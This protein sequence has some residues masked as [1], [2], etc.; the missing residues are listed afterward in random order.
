MHGFLA[1][2]LP[3][4]PQLERIPDEPQS[5]WL[6]S[7]QSACWV[8]FLAGSKALLWSCFLIVCLPW[9]PAPQ[10]HLCSGCQVP[11]FQNK[12]G[13]VLGARFGYKAVHTCPC[14][15]RACLDHLPSPHPRIVMAW[16]VSGSAGIGMLIALK[17]LSHCL[18]WPPHPRSWSPWRILTLRFVSGQFSS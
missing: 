7:S 18:T 1:S 6:S 16:N 5:S 2:R 9:R 13:R 8:N 17:Y 3:K 12:N 15:H 4:G 11:G 14:H 10:L